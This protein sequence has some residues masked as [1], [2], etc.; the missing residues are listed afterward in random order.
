MN[1]N[2]LIPSF[3]NMFTA[4]DTAFPV[5][6][7]GFACPHLLS[8][9]WH[10]DHEKPLTSLLVC[11]VGSE[12]K[13]AAV[14]YSWLHQTCSQGAVSHNHRCCHQSLLKLCQ[15][16]CSWYSHNRDILYSARRLARATDLVSEHNY[17]LYDFIIIRKD[18]SFRR[19][20][21]DTTDF[22]G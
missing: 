8:M 11:L 7:I 2:N 15:C 12:K 3:F 21:T 4:L 20:F 9:Y 10:V 19:K 17:R 16:P 22:S 13:S 14:V 18:G 6:V 5:C 1:F